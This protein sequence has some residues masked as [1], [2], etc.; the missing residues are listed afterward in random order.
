MRFARIAAV[1]LIG[2]G[3]LVQPAA[4]AATPSKGTLS[5]KVKLVKWTGSFTLSE[6]TITGG[7]LGGSGDPACDYFYLKVD[8]SDG[9]RIRIDVPAV[10]ATTDLDLFVYS[11][12]GAEVGSSGNNP[13]EAERVEF[14]HSGRFRNKPYEVRVKSF[15]AAPGT[16]YKASAK[17]R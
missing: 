5:K 14:R 15:L 1:A 4:N 13:G 12:T 6:P 11:S 7:C 10:N 9:A 16:S 17:V 2:L 3:V 8:L